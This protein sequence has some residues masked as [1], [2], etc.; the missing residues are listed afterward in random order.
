[1]LSSARSVQTD[2]WHGHLM[3]LLLGIPHDV[4]DNRTGKISA[5]IDA[6]TSPSALLRGRPPAETTR[7]D[8]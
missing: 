8:P 2:R 1:M 4:I 5:M 6:C 7:P 3:C